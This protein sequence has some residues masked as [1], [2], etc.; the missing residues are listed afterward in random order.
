MSALVVITHAEEALPLILWGGQ[1]CEGT[2]L[3][4]IDIVLLARR[5]AAASNDDFAGVRTG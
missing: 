2:G 3:G 5:R 4:S 1:V